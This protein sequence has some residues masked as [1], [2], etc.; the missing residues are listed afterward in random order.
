M[1]WKLE[2]QSGNENGNENENENKERT[3]H[4]CSVHE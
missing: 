2:M 3:Y 1:K 4:W